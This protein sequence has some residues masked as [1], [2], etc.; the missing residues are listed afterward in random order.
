[1]L[2]RLTI[3]T[4]VAAGFTG[5]MA[6]EMPYPDTIVI[7][8]VSNS[9]WGQIDGVSKIEIA[10]TVLGEL[11]NG[12]ETD[13]E[14][15]LMAYGQGTT[16]GCENIEMVL[17]VGPLVAPDFS[18]AVNSL[19]P[20]GRTP[21]VAAVDQAADSLQY[22][23]RSARIVLVSDGVE[24]CGGDLGALADR[25]GSNGLD[26]TAH[27]IAFDV[28]DAGEQAELGYLAAQTGGLF[29]SAEST[30]ELK[31]AL[32]SMMGDM[33]TPMEPEAASEGS[34]PD[35]MMPATISAPEMLAQRSR[36]EIT[37]SGPMGDGVFIGLA[38]AG[39]RDVIAVA[40]AGENGRALLI[41]PREPGR[42]ELRYF[43]QADG[44]VLATQMIEIR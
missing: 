19:T 18:A 5:A 43:T 42:Y 17:P 28:V 35:E 34:M 32:Q 16:E 21:L 20:H 44:E 6:Q 24:N 38:K 10:R 27:V 13:S 4:L 9:M 40:P 12:L 2:K 8:D 37:Y 30:A 15:G 33:E 14:F 41:A 22:Q 7:L 31:T 11:V 26:F 36:I 39:E 25:L 3:A 1:M 29:V 23:T